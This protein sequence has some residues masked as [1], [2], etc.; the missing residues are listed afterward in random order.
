MADVIS[1]QTVNSHQETGE[2][3]WSVS[4]FPKTNTIVLSGLEHSLKLL[5]G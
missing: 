2:A 4:R 3:Y 5:D 1:L